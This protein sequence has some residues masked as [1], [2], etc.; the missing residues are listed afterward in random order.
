MTQQKYRKKEGCSGHIHSFTNQK[1]VKKAM[2]ISKKFNTSDYKNNI[3]KLYP[4]KS[5][6]QSHIQV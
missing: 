3:N 4:E 2:G 5:A 1:S 6:G